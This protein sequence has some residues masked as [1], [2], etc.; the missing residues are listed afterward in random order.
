MD[1][2]KNTNIDFLKYKIPAMI[3]SA[4][5]IIAGIVSVQLKHGFRYGVEF[6]GGTA[7]HAKFRNPVQLDQV[8]K[9]LTEAGFQDSGVQGFIDPSEVLI[10][11]PEKSSNG[12]QVGEISER[13]L[14]LMNSAVL[15]Q[16]VPTDKK[17][18]NLASESDLAATLS[19]SDPLGTKTPDSYTPIAQRI[20][21]LKK[22][23]GGL[24]PRF[25]QITGID[26]K[27]ITVLKNVYYVGDVAALSSE[28]VGPEVGAD[29]RSKATLAVLWSLVGIL[30]YLW[31]RFEL[32]WS[33]SIIVCLVHDVLIALAFVSFFDREISLTVIAALLTIVGYSMNDTIVVYDRVR[34]NLRTMRTQSPEAVFN[35]SINQTLGRTILTSGTVFVVTLVLYFFGGEVI[36]DFAFCMLIGVISGTYSTVYI[37]AAVVVLYGKYFGKKKPVPVTKAKAST[38]AS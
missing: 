25:E 34:D 6:S 19:L 17:D 9:S 20:L 5:I 33:A 24:V 38:K 2:V 27:V 16:T 8:R 1:I 32:T 10:R 4:L 14:R 36:N 28:Y 13:I 3:I 7:I 23:N 35:A 22:S 15:K 26:S 29:L 37:A 21:D 11:L 12:Q 30:I 31:F 18:L